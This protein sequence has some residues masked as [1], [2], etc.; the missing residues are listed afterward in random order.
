MKA[1]TEDK[2][3]CSLHEVKGA[4]KTDDGNVTS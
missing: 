3:N 4:I 1:S 2:I